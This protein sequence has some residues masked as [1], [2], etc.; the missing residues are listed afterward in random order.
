VSYTNHTLMPEALETWPLR[1]FE[2]LLPRHLEII[3]EI[4]HRFLDDRAQRFPGDPGL[5]ARTSLID[6][7]GERRVRMARC[8]AG[9][10]SRQ[11]RIGAAF[12]A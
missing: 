8:G 9:L 11:R 1:L 7:S 12:A 3:Y 6:E 4:N 2:E 10:A 5:A